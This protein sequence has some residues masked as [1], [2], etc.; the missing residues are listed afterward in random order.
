MHEKKAFLSGTSLHCVQQIQQSAEIDTF[1]SV[2]TENK[3]QATLMLPLN[4]QFRHD[5]WINSY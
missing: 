5:L 1:W 4:G 3:F 2:Q